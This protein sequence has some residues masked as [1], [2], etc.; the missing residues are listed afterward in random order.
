MGRQPHAAS[1]AARG[2]SRRASTSPDATRSAAVSL[3]QRVERGARVGRR[4]P[5]ERLHGGMYLGERDAAAL[6][7]EA[8]DPANGRSLERRIVGL[9]HQQQ[10]LHGVGQADGTRELACRRADGGEVVGGERAVE[11]R[12]DDWVTAAAG[13]GEPTFP[14][15]S[16]GDGKPLE[17]VPTCPNRAARAVASASA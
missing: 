13:T 6:A 12:P 4:E 3:Q 11:A 1:G 9:Q 14:L 2:W 5:V 15:D 17:F 7:G 16:S 10:H 8:V